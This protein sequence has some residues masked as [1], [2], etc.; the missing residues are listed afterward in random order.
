MALKD[1]NGRYA[2]LVRMME[3]SEVESITE[4]LP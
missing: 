4:A 3:E 2:A 1:Q